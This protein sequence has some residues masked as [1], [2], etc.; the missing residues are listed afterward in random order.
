MYFALP[1]TALCLFIWFHFCKAYSR[2]L[3]LVSSIFPLVLTNCVLILGELRPVQCVDGWWP[4]AS[5]CY[6]IHRDPKTWKDAL[7]SCKKQDGDLASIHN[8]AEYSFLVSQL[9][10]SEYICRPVLHLLHLRHKR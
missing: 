9:G 4:Y 10:Y 2:D 5:H 1:T 6:S 7:S 8:I 3:I